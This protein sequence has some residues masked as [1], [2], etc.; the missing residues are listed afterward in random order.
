[1]MT[2]NNTPLTNMTDEHCQAMLYLLED[3]SLDR[4]AFEARLADDPQLGEILAQAVTTFLSLRAV[5]FESEAVARN[6]SQVSASGSVARGVPQYRSWQFVSVLAASLLIAVFLGWQTLFS[7]R[8]GSNENGS[9]RVVLA[10]GDLQIDALDIQGAHETVDSEMEYSL[11][12]N[13]LFVENDV[14]EWLVMAA[15]DAAE[16]FD[17]ESEKGLVQ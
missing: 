7:I 13:E 10:W 1:M 9:S 16:G 17:T 8:S 4:V 6:S 12:R 14:P 3:P 2:D 11:T 15:T 5:S